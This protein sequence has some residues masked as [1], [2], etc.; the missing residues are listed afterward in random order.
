MLGIL[1]GIGVGPGDPEL[2]T[3]KAVK[4]LNEVDLLFAASSTKND[5]SVALNVV[6]DHLPPATP[7]EFLDFPMTFDAGQLEQAWRRNFRKVAAALKEGKK[8][9]FI[10]IGDPMTFSTFIYLMRE[11]RAQLPQAEIRI[12]PGITS[13]QA[14]A[15]CAAVPLAEGEETM[16]IAS[17]AKGGALLKEV[18]RYS[19]NVVLMKTYRHLQDVL[20]S[21]K[22]LGYED[23]CY[24]V[25]RC[26]LDGESIER[27]FSGM[28]KIEPSYLSLMIVK[29][30][31]RK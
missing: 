9:G 11:V 1:Y 29:K 26:G 20:A 25:S 21:I 19:D 14:A 4:T 7:V 24:L 6:R 8:A 10:T 22:E 3:L 13:F 28:K 23:N 31:N 18:I 16:T 12:I 27:D 30:N 2:L 17:A 15:A 5:Y